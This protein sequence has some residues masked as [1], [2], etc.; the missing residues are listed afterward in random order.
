M[1][2]IIAIVA[3]LVFSAVVA[4]LW[5]RAGNSEEWDIH[6]ARHMALDAQDKVL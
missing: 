1:F 3:W 6:A 5:A 4:V 2:I